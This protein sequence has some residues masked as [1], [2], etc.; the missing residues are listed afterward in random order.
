VRRN[1]KVAFYIPTPEFKTISAHAAVATE[2]DELVALTG[3]HD[4]PESLADA[5]LFA[6]APDLLDLV[7]EFATFV[8]EED[9]PGRTR[10]QYAL[11]DKGA[12]L[13]ARLE[14]AEVS[15]RG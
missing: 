10:A 7:R 2:A 9:L 14:R 12:A 5:A 15:S 6:A 4:H 3:P 1:L 8:G 11:L 13:V